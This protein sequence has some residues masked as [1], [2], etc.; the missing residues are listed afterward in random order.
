MPIILDKDLYNIAKSE[1][2]KIY[3]KSSA[4]KSGFSLLLGCKLPKM[5]VKLPAIN[6]FN[7]WCES[8]IW[9]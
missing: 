2:D 9:F 8:Y 5:S 3:K 6:G 4:Y 7:G 1:A